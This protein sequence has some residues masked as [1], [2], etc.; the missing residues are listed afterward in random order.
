MGML[1]MPEAAR[2]LHEVGVD[3]VGLVDFS[4]Y[5]FKDGDELTFQTFMEIV[6]Q[7]RGKNTAT[8]KD[9]V[10]LRKLIM[11]ELERLSKNMEALTPG[12]GGRSKTIKTKDHNWV[13]QG[14]C[15]G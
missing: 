7:L 11:P 12:N 5:I 6:L 8:V 3:V 2:A 4:D 14:T 13:K 15:G 10:D 1:H 9:I